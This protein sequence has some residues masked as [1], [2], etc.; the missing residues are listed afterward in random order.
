MNKTPQIYR[1]ISL[2]LEFWMAHKWNESIP[3]IWRFTIYSHTLDYIL[4]MVSASAD[5]YEMQE[6]KE[7]NIKKIIS[8]LNKVR[9]ITRMFFEKKVISVKQMNHIDEIYEKISNQ[10]NKWLNSIKHKKSE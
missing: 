9:L 7:E 3:K 6:G 4:E 5:A 10:A 2:V 8:N 1:D